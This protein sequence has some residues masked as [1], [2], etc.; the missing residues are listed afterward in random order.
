MVHS[1]HREQQRLLPHRHRGARNRREQRLDDLQLHAVV[2]LVA[3]AAHGL[4]DDVDEEPLRRALLHTAG[5]LEVPE[6]CTT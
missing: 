1:A 3:A 5:P 4:N 6:G 2:R